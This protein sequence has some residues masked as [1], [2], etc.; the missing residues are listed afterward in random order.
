ML[1]HLKGAG[2]QNPYA[3]TPKGRLSSP[4]SLTQIKKISLFQNT[5]PP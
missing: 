1:Q 4:P 5:L 2:Q 3:S